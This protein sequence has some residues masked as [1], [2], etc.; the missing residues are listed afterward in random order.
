[1]PEPELSQ[2]ETEVRY[3]NIGRIPGRPGEFE[4]VF[5]RL[6]GFGEAAD[7]GKSPREEHPGEH[8]GEHELT[9][10]LGSVIS[11]KQRDGVGQAGNR[12]ARVMRLLR[13]TYG[14]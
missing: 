4:A 9:E 5:G 13:R 8:T 3:E 1:V 10:S 14:L 2:T 12:P 11:L 7:I 6:Q